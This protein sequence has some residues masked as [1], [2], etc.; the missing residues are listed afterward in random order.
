MNGDYSVQQQR[1]ATSFRHA[2]TTASVPPFLTQRRK[3]ALMCLLERASGEDRIRPVV[4][5]F[6]CLDGGLPA[7]M[8][9]ARQ[10]V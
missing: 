4:C 1:L 7:E 3:R 2:A 9:P 10:A 8:R 6:A 5:Y